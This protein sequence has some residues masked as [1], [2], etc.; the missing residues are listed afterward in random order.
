[1]GRFRSSMLHAV[2]AMTMSGCAPVP[3][4]SFTLLTIP[5]AGIGTCESGQFRGDFME[6]SPRSGAL[7]VALEFGSVMRPPVR[8]VRIILDS[9]GKML[10]FRDEISYA[11]SGA[12]VA[13][14]FAPDGS[15]A[16]GMEHRHAGKAGSRATAGDRRLRPE[17]YATVIEAVRKL[18]ER[19]G[20]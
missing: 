17:R 15:I 4:D 5:P 12:S 1:M 20:A 13:V 16:T 9:A 10:S 8:S 2:A 7:R 18:R 6:G 11:D 14:A 19:C 3:V